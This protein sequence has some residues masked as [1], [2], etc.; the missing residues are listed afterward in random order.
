M[1]RICI[2]YVITLVK[3]KQGLYY[4]HIILMYVWRHRR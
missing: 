1:I 4:L 2:H 3:N